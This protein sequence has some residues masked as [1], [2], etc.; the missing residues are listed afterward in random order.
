[1]GYEE[2][3]SALRAEGERKAAMIREKAAAEAARL[4]AKAA[5]GLA[6]LEE[7]CRQEQAREIAAQDSAII[8]EAEREAR[9]IQLVAE[10]KLAE[11]LFELAHRILPKLRTGGYS[12]AFARL[13]AELPPAAREEIRVNPADAEAAVALFPT[14]RIV[15][16][17]AICGGLEGLVDGGRVQVVNTLEKRLERGWPELLPLLLGEIVNGA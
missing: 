15:A 16:D 7:K 1:M 11:R 8:A 10:E 4:R 14:A 3:L 5:D 6:L 17:A 9:R 12:A 13:A 2:L